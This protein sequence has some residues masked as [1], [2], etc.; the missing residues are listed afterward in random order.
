MVKPSGVVIRV[1]FIVLVSGAL[2]VLAILAM[3]KLACQY[4]SEAWGYC[5]VVL[6]QRRADGGAVGITC[7]GWLGE[8]FGKLSI[9]V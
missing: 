1:Q 8:G 3:F 7:T 9:T 6:M 5:D 4:P 2:E